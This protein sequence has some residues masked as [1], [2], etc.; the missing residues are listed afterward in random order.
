[1]VVHTWSS[2]SYAQAGNHTSTSRFTHLIELAV[3]GLQQPIE[4]H[5]HEAT[6]PLLLV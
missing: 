6:S 1:M 3:L 5:L 2:D 4:R